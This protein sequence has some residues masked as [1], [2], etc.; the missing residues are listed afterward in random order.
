MI[1]IEKK[2]LTLVQLSSILYITSSECSGFYNVYK[3]QRFIKYKIQPCSQIIDTA[4]ACYL[5]A[6]TIIGKVSHY[7]LHVHALN[8]KIK[9]QFSLRIESFLVSM[10]YISM[11]VKIVNCNELIICINVNK[12]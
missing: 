6:K 9:F 1:I 7:Q 4:Y 2:S 11:L 12:S 5:Q 10:Y 8:L 3:W